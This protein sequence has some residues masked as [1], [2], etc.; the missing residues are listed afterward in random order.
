M[1]KHLEIFCLSARLTTQNHNHL[2]LFFSPYSC[3]VLLTTVIVNKNSS[4]LEVQIYINAGCQLTELSNASVS[5]S[6]GVTG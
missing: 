2:S 1:K 6:S 5:H 4:S 3:L